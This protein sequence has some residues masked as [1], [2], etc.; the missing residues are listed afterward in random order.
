MAAETATGGGGVP[1]SRG[2]VRPPVR[3]PRPGRGEEDAAET[4]ARVG[5]SPRRC[6]EAAEADRE[7]GGRGGEGV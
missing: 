3:A 1:S 7:E 2:A 5:S 6:E 4:A